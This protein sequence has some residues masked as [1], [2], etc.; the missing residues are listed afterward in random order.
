MNRFFALAC[1]AAFPLAATAQ[2]YFSDDF[3][4]D[5]TTN[6][7]FNSSVA[8]DLPAN[9]LNNEA[10]YFFDYS[11]VGIPLAPNSAAG[12]TRG[13]KM[14]T[15]V[16]GSGVFSGFS[17]SPLGLSLSGDY[18]LY[19]D[20]W[21]NFQGPFPGG[22]SGTTQMLFA[23]IGVAA[24]ATQFPGTNIN[25]VGFSATGDG[26][27]SADYR[28]YTAVG[29]P[30]DPST[31]VYAAG[32][33]STARNNTDPYY[34]GFVGTVPAA[35]TAWANGQGFFD[36]TGSTNPGAQGMAWRRWKIQ[37]TGTSASWYID[38]LRIATVDNINFTGDNFYVGM[39]DINASSSTQTISRDL[40]FGLVDNVQVVPEP[41]SLVALGLGA[42]ALLRRRRK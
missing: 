1:A 19:F 21:I 39:F 22:G 30:L 11:S 12:G 18:T 24:T 35:Q 40:L 15:N 7:S 4:V 27:T 17:T 36:Q 6:Y 31:G 23:G 32:S 42:A 2:I 20:A 37:K 25:G 9:N 14:E 29:S 10:N 8:G 28:A 33:H 16:I 5:P 38:G 3:E 41:T 26:G 13:L 34:A